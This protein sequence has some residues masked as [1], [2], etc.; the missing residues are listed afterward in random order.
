MAGSVDE[1]SDNI[2]PQEG[3]SITCSSTKTTSES[4]LESLLEIELP[5]DVNLC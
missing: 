3:G 2:W 1:M 4:T 5:K